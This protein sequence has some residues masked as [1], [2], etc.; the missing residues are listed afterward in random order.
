MMDELSSLRNTKYFST[1]DLMQ[2]FY[3]IEMD[4]ASKE[5]TAFS[6]GDS[7][8]QW[9]RMPFGLTNSPASFM[10]L[11]SLVLAGVPWSVAISYIDDVIVTGTSF[12]EHLISL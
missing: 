12:E 10:R 6:T 7:H 4:D 3:Q 8:W 11:I 5:Y 2:G 9:K 1:F